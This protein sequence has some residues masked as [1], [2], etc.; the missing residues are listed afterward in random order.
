MPLPIIMLVLFIGMPMLEIYVLIQVGQVIGPLWT[1]ALLLLVA[2]LGSLLLRQQGLATLAKVQTALARGEL[3]AGAILEGLVLL[4]AGVLMV[5][6]GFVTDVMAFLCLL[7]PL[8][9]GIVALLAHALSLRVLG[10]GAPRGPGPGPAG[11]Q[12]LEGDYRVE[13]DDP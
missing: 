6:P 5:T 2:A 13:R 4:V 11:P 9:K 12:V 1:V 10:G 7:P 8:R 3:P